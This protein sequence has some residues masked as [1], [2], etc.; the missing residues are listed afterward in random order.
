L[1]HYFKY[2]NGELLARDQANHKADQTKRMAEER[3]ARLERHKQEAL[4]AAAARKAAA[5]PKPKTMEEAA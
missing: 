3:Q 5:K 2:A 4:A 1:V